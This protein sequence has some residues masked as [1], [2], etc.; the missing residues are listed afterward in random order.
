[1]VAGELAAPGQVHR[2]APD[3]QR[4]RQQHRVD[5]ADARVHGREGRPDDERAQDRHDPR[6]ARAHSRTLATS[7]LT[8]RVMSL[9]YCVNSGEKRSRT[10]GSLIGKICRMRPGTDVMTTTRSAR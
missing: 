7:S 4:R 10:S 1:E 9:S 3:L 6:E 8:T 2:D 5:E